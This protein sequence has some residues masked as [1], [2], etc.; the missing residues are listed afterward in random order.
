MTIYKEI[1]SSKNLHL[2]RMHFYV[3]QVVLFKFVE[4]SFYKPYSLSQTRKC[5]NSS[6]FY[7]IFLSCCAYNVY[8]IV[9]YSLYLSV[10]RSFLLSEFFL[11]F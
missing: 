4:L 8:L 10:S 9:E 3:A 2:K 1:K 7:V 6:F 11:V 5:D